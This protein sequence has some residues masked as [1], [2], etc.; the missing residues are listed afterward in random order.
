M[1]EAALTRIDEVGGEDWAYNDTGRPC[2]PGCT[3]TACAGTPRWT[4]TGTSVRSSRSAV[5]STCCVMYELFDAQR[6]ALIG[7]RNGGEI[8]DQ[9][10]RKVERELDLEESR[11]TPS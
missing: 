9:V 6:E 8:S 10:R 11:L 7:L 3:T 5:T 2:P 1:A 4:G